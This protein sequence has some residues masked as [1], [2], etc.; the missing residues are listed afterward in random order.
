LIEEEDLKELKNCYSNVFIDIER[1]STGRE[2]HYTDY[3]M[4][5]GW[6][7]EDEVIMRNLE[8]ATA[9]SSSSM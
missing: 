8:A 4:H 6:W 5:K 1:V 9:L 3:I 7:M 2:P